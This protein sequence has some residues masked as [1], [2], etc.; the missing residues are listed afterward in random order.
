VKL[1]SPNGGSPLNAGEETSITWTIYETAQSITK[2]L[3][4]YT[5]DGGT[6]WRSINTLTDIS[7]PGPGSYPRTVPVVGANGKTKCKVKIILKDEGSATRG[8]DVSDAFFTIQPKR[9]L[10]LSKIKQK[11]ENNGKQHS[12]SSLVFLG[13]LDDFC[14]P[15]R[16][17]YGVV[18]RPCGQYCGLHSI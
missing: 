16:D 17:L 11:G 5:K 12:V 9:A 18:E 3:L 2:I 6:T 10:L 14:H 13:G 1:D 7:S 15:S 8:Q 4:Y